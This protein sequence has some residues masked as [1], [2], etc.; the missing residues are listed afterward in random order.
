MRD[1]ILLRVFFLFVIGGAVGVLATPTPLLP[2]TNP[3][4]SLFILTGILIFV[5]LLMVAV[6]YYIYSTDNVAIAS[7]T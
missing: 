7:S 5:F 1:S 6:V 2:T 3:D 4:T